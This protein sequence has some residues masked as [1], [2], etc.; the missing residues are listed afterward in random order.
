MRKW[1]AILLALLTLLAVGCNKEPSEPVDVVDFND[2]TPAATPP[3]DTQ[4]T[5]GTTGYGSGMTVAGLTHSLGVRTDGTVVATG[6]NT[7]GQCDVSGWTNIIYAAAGDKISVGVKEDGTVV[8]AGASMA[9][10]EDLASWTDVKKVAV[11]DGIIVG[12]SKDGI[13]MGIGDC[14]DTPFWT[15]LTD[16][17]AAGKHI[18][19]LKDDGTV[20]VTGDQNDPGWTGCIAIDA[21]KTSVVAVKADGTALTTGSQALSA[22]NNLVG[23]A[24][25][26]TI[27]VGVKKD[28]TVV[29]DGTDDVSAIATAVSASGGANHAL[30]MLYD[31]KVVGLGNN[32]NYQTRTSA[33]EL[34]P[35][36]D[37]GYLVGFAPGAKAQRVMDIFND[38]YNTTSAEIK[39]PAE[40]G[41]VDRA[42][43]TP[44]ETV[45]TGAEA[46][47]NGESI[48]TIV[49]RGDVSGD[50][51][52]DAN[53]SG[54]INNHILGN[55]QLDAMQ[56][57]AASIYT[58]I[59]GEIMKASVDA[60]DG[61]VTNP[62][63]I[64]PQFRSATGGDTYNEK[65]STAKQTNE[66]VTGWITLPGTNIDFPIMKATKDFHY[67]YY[68]WDNKKDAT[69]ASYMY[70][71]EARQGQ[72]YAFTAHNNR[73]RAAEQPGD[74]SSMFHDLHH[75]YDK[76]L[77]RT[78]CMYE[79]CGAELGAALPDLKTYSGRVWDLNILGEEGLWEVFSVYCT[80]EETKKSNI[81]TLYENIWFDTDEKDWG[82]SDKLDTLYT[83]KVRSKDEIRSWIDKQIGKSEI[84]LGVNV[85][86]NDKLLT[87]VT[88]GTNSSAAGERL[89]YFLHKVG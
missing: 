76:N 22:W 16:I 5:D 51:I 35:F 2:E 11:G 13:G 12:I 38:I 63:S 21:N 28:G 41:S 70:Y 34:R 31:G 46:F 64:I 56:L 32:D 37:N 3:V 52:I 43:M 23:I 87:V 73:K 81:D 65:I 42:V 88:C 10:I 6:Q 39:K 26:D 24:A 29:T 27:T 57:V 36:S 55:N 89:Y 58:N 59:N 66:D 15:N 49:I 72:F 54:A 14:G 20:V 61:Y 40:A 79:K 85:S 84:E 48:G 86:E 71:N 44:D 19:A 82:W 77:G 74:P 25:G 69:A 33:W 83:E 50:G 53:D 47:V 4:P 75:I 45:F 78:T 18:I 1:I 30:V 68:T 60:V 62:A 8:W 80:T 7:D 17:K 9:G 67:N